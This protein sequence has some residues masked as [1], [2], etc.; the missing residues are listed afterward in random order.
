MFFLGGRQKVIILTFGGNKRSLIYVHGF[1]SRE[2]VMIHAF[3]KH[4][5]QIENEYLFIAWSMHTS[6]SISVIFLNN[7]GK[8]KNKQHLLQLHVDLKFN[9][10]AIISFL[11]KKHSN[12]IPAAKSWLEITMIRFVVLDELRRLKITRSILAFWFWRFRRWRLAA[13]SLYHFG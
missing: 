10:Y 8:T 1:R 6:S 5:F 9:M 4:F 3:C 12:F 11:L 2:W 13:F 7:F